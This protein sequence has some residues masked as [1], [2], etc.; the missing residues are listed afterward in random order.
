MFAWLTRLQ[1]RLHRNTRHRHTLRYGAR[2][3]TGWGIV[4]CLT[5]ERFWD[6]Y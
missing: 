4:T 3:S 2:S 6:I 1:N 5:C